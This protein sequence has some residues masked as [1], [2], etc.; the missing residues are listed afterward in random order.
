MRRRGLLALIAGATTLPLLGARAQQ[1]KIPQ[2]GYL[3]VGLPPLSPAFWQG[4]HDLGYVE[5]H[6]IRVEYRWAEG[7][8]E[9]TCSGK[10][11][12]SP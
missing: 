5:G 1:P 11:E 2:L 9:W 12:S 6:N 8:P 10:V 3:Y 4:M 7:V